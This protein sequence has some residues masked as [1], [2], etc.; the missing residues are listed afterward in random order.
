MV[1]ASPF[2]GKLNEDANAPL[3]N[4]LELC[5]TVT[6]RGVTVERYHAPSVSHFPLGEGE[7]MVLP[8]QRSH[9][10]VGQKETK[11]QPEVTNQA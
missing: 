7:T 6:I 9:Q 11:N 4:F 10:Y 2:C 1:Q 3:Q 5:K 8:E